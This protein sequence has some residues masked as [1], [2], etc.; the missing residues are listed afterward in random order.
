[1]R[2]C[3]RRW[4]RSPT[5][6]NKNKLKEIRKEYKDLKKNKSFES[7]NKFVEL[8]DDP[9]KILSISLEDKPSM[10]S[11]LKNEHGVLL[12]D[13]RENAE[14]LLNKIF[15]DDDVESD[16]E[17][18]TKIRKEVENYFL[19]LDTNDLND[20]PEVTEFEVFRA[21]DEMSPYK[22]VP[23]EIY[24]VLIKAGNEVFYF[25]EKRKSCRCAKVW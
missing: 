25:M 3:E 8:C 15:P 13:N 22:S 23:D 1:M 19:T 2:K 6:E 17:V 5:E 24:P 12:E 9:Y 21:F 16:N 14:F 18:S 7:F 10:K 20:F 4:K 11:F